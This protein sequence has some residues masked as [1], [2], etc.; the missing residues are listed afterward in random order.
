[1]AVS[2]GVSGMSG[3]PSRARRAVIRPQPRSAETFRAAAAISSGSSVTVG[4]GAG[5]SSILQSRAVSPS[6]PFPLR[7][8][9]PAAGIPRALLRAS[10]STVT[11]RLAASSSRFTH[12][13]VRGCSSI[14]CM[15]RLRFRWRQLASQTT[16]TAS[17]LPWVMTSRADISSAEPPR[18][19]YIPGMS[20][21]RISLPSAEK[22]PSAGATVLPDQLPV[23]WSR[24]VRA[25]NTVD[26]PT[27][28]FPAST[29][30]VSFFI[31]LPLSTSYSPGEL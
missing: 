1:M 14:I 25:L 29:T 11:P 16:M 20:R 18:R 22:C 6:S 27:F 13:S 21:S 9:V 30:F 4:F 24:T 3:S 15:A 2:S 26:L 23:C 8:E 31:K 28:G 12:R 10:V 5:E 19:E 7:A 17:A